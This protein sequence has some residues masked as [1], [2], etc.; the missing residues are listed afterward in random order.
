MEER[1]DR[2]SIAPEVPSATTYEADPVDQIVDDA[3]RPFV[4]NWHQLVSSTNWE[5]GRII[6]TW[7]QA[8][9]ASGAEAS[10]YSDEVWAQLVGEVT[11][12][13]VGRLRRVFDRF[14]VAHPEYPGLYWSHFHAAL[15]W[16]DAEIWL[17][18]AV[19]QKWSIAAMRRQ[20]DQVYNQGTSLDGDVVT[21]RLTRDTEAATP[22][23]P[24]DKDLTIVQDLDGPGP[25]AAATDDEDEAEE[26]SYDQS[27]TPQ[28]SVPKSRPFANLAQLPDDM[29]DAFESFKLA[30]LHHKLTGWAAIDLPDVLAS[31]DA[32]KQL[33]QAPSE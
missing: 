6:A 4:G 9:I 12:Q 22:P 31:L 28:S 29:A 19:Q 33:A 1:M 20:R 16:E 21:S 15:D 23:S 14:G 32:L 13:H 26:S 10:A 11:S 5:K 30:I 25:I 7:R 3:S 8:L 18:G 27:L 24:A 17:E 2:S